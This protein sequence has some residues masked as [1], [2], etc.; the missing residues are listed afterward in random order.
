MSSIFDNN[1]NYVLG[2]PALELIG[3]RDKLAQWRHKGM[4]PAFYRLGRKIVYRGADL[5]EW[6]NSHRVE[7]GNAES[8]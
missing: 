1:R 6:A 7:P 3:D 8:K 5:N 2:D 4:G